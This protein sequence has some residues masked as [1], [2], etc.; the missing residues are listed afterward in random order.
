MTMR[1]NECLDAIT[2]ELC[3]AGI[4]YRVEQGKKHLKVNWMMNGRHEAEIIPINGGFRYRSH[5]NSRANI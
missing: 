3:A 5:K 2:G 4:A 1:K